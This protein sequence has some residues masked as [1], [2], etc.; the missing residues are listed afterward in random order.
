[1]NISKTVNGIEIYTKGVLLN[2]VI[3]FIHGNS[4]NAKTFI[5]QFNLIDNIPLVAIN[6]P[7]HGNS[8]R[9]E[10]PD[11]TYN[12]PEFVQ[13]I[14]QIVSELK[15]GNLILVGHSLGGHIAIECLKVMESL[16]G[17][18]IFGTPPITVPPMMEEMFLPNPQ[19]AN[20][21]NPD[22]NQ[23]EAMSLAAEMVLPIN[24]YQN[25][26]VKYILNTDPNFRKGIATS[27]G[28]GKFENEIEILK[29]SK[30]PVVILHGE[31]D[32]I[33]NSNYLRSIDPMLLWNQRI[34]LIKE[35]GHSPQL[36]TPQEF[37]K[38]L[39]DFYSDLTGK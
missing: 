9:P 34:H 30:V 10:I 28:E 1:M 13:I 29:N 14:Q 7:G 21:F 27:I 19:L 20:L 16:K 23:S 15:I 31:K 11:V 38:L 33:V 22:L 37:N 5:N 36:E 12:I 25:D 35:A 26:F 6:L 17:L 24:T 18:F 2:N 39:C 3:L 32:K 4:L 8:F